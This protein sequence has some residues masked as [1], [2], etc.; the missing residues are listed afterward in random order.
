[1]GLGRELGTATVP[2]SKRLNTRGATLPTYVSTTKLNDAIQDVDSQRSVAEGTSEL[3]TFICKK[4]FL[5]SAA[6][7][8]VSSQLVQEIE[9]RAIVS[10]QQIGIVKT[11]ISAKQRDIRLLELTS[12]ELGTLSKDTNVY[13]GVGKMY[14]FFSPVAAILNFC[15]HD[16][17]D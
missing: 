11:Q 9:S 13:E 8:R 6:K 14:V 12:S 1:M 17:R 16:G 4:V 7:S 2:L 10:Q 3:E 5:T 15:I